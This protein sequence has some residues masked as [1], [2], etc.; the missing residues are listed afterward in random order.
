MIIHGIN[1]SSSLL[2]LVDELTAPIQLIHLN[3]TTSRLRRREMKCTILT[4]PNTTKQQIMLTN[5]GEQIPATIPRSAEAALSSIRL[6]RKKALR[7]LA[8]G[9]AKAENRILHRPDLRLAS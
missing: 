1:L 7:G 4:R 3:H 8:R 6:F 5:G 2:Y 9:R